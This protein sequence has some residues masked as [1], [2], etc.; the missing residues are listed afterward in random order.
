MGEVKKDVEGGDR[1]KEDG[2]GEKE[3]SPCPVLSILATQHSL[4]EEQC[5][6]IAG[7][8]VCI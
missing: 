8:H 5:H 1:E 7:C 3:M 2:K 6:F 4:L